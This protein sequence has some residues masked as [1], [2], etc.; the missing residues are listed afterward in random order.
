MKTLK[1]ALPM[2]FALFIVGC[3][4][5]SKPPTSAVNEPPVQTIPSELASAMTTKLDELS[6]AE[7]IDV[8]NPPQIYDSNFD[9][10]ALVIVWGTLRPTNILG[11]P[12]IDWSGN[13][14][15][16]GVG[17]INPVHPIDFEPETDAIIADSLPGFVEWTSTTLLE[18]DGIA[19]I[20]RHDRRVVYIVSPRLQFSTAPFAVELQLDQLERF[21]GIF[22]VDNMNAVAVMAHRIH[23]NVCARG[24]FRGVWT[25]DDISG[26]SGSMH[27]IWFNAN[28]DSVGRYSG[29]YWVAESGDYLFEGAISALVTDDVKGH[30]RGTWS[31][32]DYRMCPAPECGT[33]HGQFRGKL[34]YLSSGSIGEISGEFGD[35]SGNTAM[36]MHGD[37]RLFCR[38]SNSPR[39]EQEME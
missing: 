31:F 26:L 3:G 12:I 36:P 1:L 33:S 15:F 19:G 7:G 8:R 13:M 5:E 35:Y 38:D 18:S 39:A 21:S 25:R 27:G 23:R 4:E 20:V 2:L 9:Y 32:D 28:G 10:Y 16:N 22:P 29:K 24:G 14:N 6:G 30:F 37:W 34:T 17:D 11:G